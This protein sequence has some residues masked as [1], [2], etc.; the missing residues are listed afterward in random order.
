MNYLKVTSRIVYSTIKWSNLSPMPFLGICS[1]KFAF[2]I[3]HSPTLTKSLIPTQ[4]LVSKSFSNSENSNVTEESKKKQPVK[5]EFCDKIFSQKGSLKRH[6]E[7]VHQKLKP[8]KCEECGE[9]F[10]RK[11]SLKIHMATVHLKSKP[12]KC[13]ECGDAFGHKSSLKMHMDT[14]HLKLKPYKCEECGEAFGRKDYLKTHMDTVHHPYKCKYCKEL[15]DDQDSL[16]GHIS[17]VHKNLT[18]PIKTEFS[19]EELSDTWKNINQMDR[20][21]NRDEETKIEVMKYFLLKKRKGK[22]HSKFEEYDYLD[23][24][25]DQFLQIENFEKNNEI[26]IFLFSLEERH[27]IK[28]YLFQTYDPEFNDTVCPVC[29]KVLCSVPYL[30]RHIQEVHLNIRKPNK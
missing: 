7:T 16:D 25:L 29:T 26:S 13:D 3:Q 12:H 28:S 6:M 2:Q 24:V 19:W 4:T 10:S 30:Q 17:L 21:K 11:Y 23:K 27:Y 20:V 18:D 5:C 14:V 8:H 9:A 1:R 15:F 22:F